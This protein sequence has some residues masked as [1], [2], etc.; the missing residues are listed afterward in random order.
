MKGELV[1]SPIFCIYREKAKFYHVEI[2]P[3]ERSIRCKAYIFV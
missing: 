2:T 1:W 3:L